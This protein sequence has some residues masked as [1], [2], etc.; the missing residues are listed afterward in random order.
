MDIKEMLLNFVPSCEQEERDREFLLKYI[1]TYD[2]VL[3][4]DNVVG[5]FT[6]SGFI[7]N[8]DRTKCLMIHHNIYNAWDFLHVAVKEAEEETGI[9]KER[10]KVLTTTPATLEILTV[11]GHVKRGKYVSSHLHLNVAYLLE[12]DDSEEIRIKPDENSGIQWIELDKLEESGVETKMLH[13]YRKL[14]VK[15]KNI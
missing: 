3:T 1:E 14:I 7:V 9:P 13:T 6:S 15:A 10:I 5:H 8:K 4:R 11:D 12:V 2:D